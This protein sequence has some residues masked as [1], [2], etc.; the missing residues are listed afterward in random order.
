M[1]VCF[2]EGAPPSYEIATSIQCRSVS[3]RVP[4]IRFTLAQDKN[5]QC[6]DKNPINLTEDTTEELDSNMTQ[7]QNRVYTPNGYKDFKTPVEVPQNGWTFETAW[8]I[9]LQEGVIDKDF[10]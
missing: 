9:L 1:F 10:P 6:S 2:R 4:F 7:E 3:L 5:K 8:D